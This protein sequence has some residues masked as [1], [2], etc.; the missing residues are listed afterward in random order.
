MKAIKLWTP[1]LFL[2]SM[3]S[4]LG[5]ISTLAQDAEPAADSASYRLFMPVAM[6]VQAPASPLV[7]GNFESGRS[8][9]TES[10]TH[11][12]P[13]IVTQFAGDIQARSG[14]WAA[15]LGGD[16]NETSVLSQQVTVPGGAAAYLVYWHWIASEDLCGYDKLEV[17]VNGAVRHSYSL[18]TNNET[19]DWRP[20]SVNL[21]PFAGQTINLQFRV[22]TDGTLNS[23]LFIDDVGFQ[24]GPALL[25]DFPAESVV[26]EEAQA[27]K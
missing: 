20:V 5:T 10:S 16:D 2:L 14:Q 11:N 19:P 12:Y 8:G 27:T 3:V 6:N 23:N 18:C 9:W 4:L 21:N 22:T 24:A 13:L 26:D 25:D 7:N 15:W 17:R 1:V